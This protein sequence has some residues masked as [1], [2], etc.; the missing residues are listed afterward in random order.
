MW[1]IFYI[2]LQYKYQYGA[3]E[4]FKSSWSGDSRT[5]KL[6]IS[7][8]QDSTQDLEKYRSTELA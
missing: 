5:S 2:T 6:E 7:Y 1:V 3:R 4:K 8:G